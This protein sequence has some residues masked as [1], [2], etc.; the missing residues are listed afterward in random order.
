MGVFFSVASFF[1]QYYMTEM[2]PAICA[3]FGIGLVV[4][5][6]DYRRPGWRGWLLPIAL[7]VTVAEQVHI[8]T[9]YPTWSQWLIPL[10]VVLCVIA[11]A[12]LVGAR[13]APLIAVKAPRARYLLPALGAGVL[14]LMLAPSV[15]AAIPVIQNT[16]A[17]LPVAGPSQAN[18]FG[19]NFS[20]GRG[21][22][23]GTDQALVSY[24]EANQGNA[25]YLVA[26]PSSM[27]ADGIILATNKP[28]MALGGFGGSDPILTTDQLAALVS[29]GTVRFFLLGSFR[30]SGQPPAQFL[31][32]IPEQFRERF[33]DEFGGRGGFGG[34]Q[35][36]ALTSWVTQH[37]TVVPASQWQS[38]TSNTQNVPGP[39]G[40]NQLYDCVT[41]H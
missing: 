7:I 32:D 28:V 26:T 41:T 25:T 2:A 10:M 5:W 24:L 21:N 12:V 27:T 31:Q 38:S 8:L 30:D 6:Q 14:A 3:L 29:Q 17:Q 36:S 39:G 33:G 19:G 22:N 15:W 20:G 37:C 13:L 4:M 23:G 11:V 1:H 34:G 16:T 35:Q 40:A 18:G 9:Y